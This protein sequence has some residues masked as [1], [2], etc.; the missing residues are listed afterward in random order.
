MSVR[1]ST[2]ETFEDE[3]AV[4]N[5]VR[6]RVDRLNV[7]MSTDLILVLGGTGKTGRRIALRLR[8]TAS[9]CAPRPDK[10]RRPFDWADPATYDAALA[11]VGALTWSRPA[12][13]PTSPPSWTRCST[14]PRPPVSAT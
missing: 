1:T 14:W 8:S 11:G 2:G 5:M 6:A 7:G 4:F 3:Y 13:N 12:S 9:T 10:A